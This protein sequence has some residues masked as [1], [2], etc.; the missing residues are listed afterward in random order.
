[1][2]CCLSLLSPGRI[3]PGLEADVFSQAFTDTSSIRCRQNRLSLAVYH[4][5]MWQLCGHCRGRRRFVLSAS[6][7]FESASVRFAVNHPNLTPLLSSLSSIVLV[8]RPCSATE[9]R[10]PKENLRNP[11]RRTEVDSNFMRSNRKRVLPINKG[12]N[13]STFYLTKILFH[14]KA[15]RI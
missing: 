12:A 2:L 13:R 1:M 9:P 3:A 10:V 15:L 5:L 8:W 4:K 6:N 14:L 7:A 11:W